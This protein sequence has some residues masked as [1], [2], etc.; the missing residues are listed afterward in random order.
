MPLRLLKKREILKITFE[1]EKKKSFVTTQ[2]FSLS[3]LTHHHPSIPL[4]NRKLKGNPIK[5]STVFPLAFTIL[6]KCIYEMVIWLRYLEQSY[7]LIEKG[8]LKLKRADVMRR[9]MKWNCR[10]NT[11]LCLSNQVENIILYTELY[12][13]S[14]HEEN[15]FFLSHKRKF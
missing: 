6:L 13:L 10:R 8:I 4:T 15:A 1:R 12:T 2:K 11:L 9:E 5:R 7:W 14:F 3:Q